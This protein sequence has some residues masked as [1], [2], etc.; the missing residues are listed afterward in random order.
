MIIK[1]FSDLHLEFGSDYI[2]DQLFEDSLAN[3]FVLAG[4]LHVNRKV[5]K[6]L[7]KFDG[8]TAN[9]PLIF[10]PGNHEYYGTQRVELDEQL[11]QL[12][13][14]LKNVHILIEDT[15]KIGEVTFAGSTGWW[16]S[17]MRGSHIYALNDFN[18][19]YDI[20][21]YGN[22]TMWGQDAFKFFQK[23]LDKTLNVVCVSHNAPSWQSIN[24]KY[25]NSDINECFANKWDKMIQSYQ[26]IAWIHGHMHDPCN[27]EIGR[28]Q[29]A[30]NPYGYY[31]YETSS[32]FSN[33]AYIQVL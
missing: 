29:V 4:D 19:I 10:V 2:I 21:V 31:G 28:T 30:C 6:V 24:P 13:K 22:G 5:L 27:Y 7:Q 16:D 32:E 17:P 11:R 26:P 8:M 18:R 20:K 25:I 3:V 14:S 23:V 12:N 9:R 15:I 33:T 1:Y